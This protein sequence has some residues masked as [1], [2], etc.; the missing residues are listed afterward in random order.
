M[1]DMGCDCRQPGIGSH[2][3]NVL[4]RQPVRPRRD[5]LSRLGAFGLKKLLAG[6]IL[7]IGTS[8][9]PESHACSNIDQHPLDMCH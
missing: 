2:Q 5:N 4:P 8:V 3:S 9:A 1:E 6:A 7:G